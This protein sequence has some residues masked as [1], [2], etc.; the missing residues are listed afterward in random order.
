MLAGT[1]VLVLGCGYAWLSP[2]RGQGPLP[3]ETGASTA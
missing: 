2:L 1:A 3:S